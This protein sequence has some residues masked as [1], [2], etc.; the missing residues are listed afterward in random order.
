[1]LLNFKRIWTKR[2]TDVALIVGGLA[3]TAVVQ[4]LIIKWP[5]VATN[6]ILSFLYCILFVYIMVN[7]IVANNFMFRNQARLCGSSVSL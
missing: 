4:M 3:L 1:M 6:S 7:D 2:F 5:T